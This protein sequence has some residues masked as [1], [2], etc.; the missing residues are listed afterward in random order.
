VLPFFDGERTPNL[1]EASGLVIGLRHDTPPGAILMATYEGALGALLDALE[2]VGSCS[3]G[4]DP[5]APL[6]VIGG[7]ARGRTWQRAAARLSGRQLRI[8]RAAELVALGAAVQA[9]MVLTGEEPETIAERWGTQGGTTIDPDEVSAD[10]LVRV[11]AARTA[12]VSSGLFSR[13]F[14]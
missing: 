8:P 1:P 4:I 10:T 2:Q 13:S 11:R 6:V 3:S 5:R 14:S 7:G 12:A 9:T